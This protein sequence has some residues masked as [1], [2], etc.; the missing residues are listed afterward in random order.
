MGI[1]GKFVLLGGQ[2]V[3]FVHGISFRGSLLR[4]I[5]WPIPLLTGL[6]LRATLV[7]Q[8][9]A[10]SSDF[11]DDETWAIRYMTVE[12]GG[13]L[14]GRPVLISSISILTWIGKR[15]GWTWH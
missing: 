7:N 12:T 15:S 5:G 14:G 11:F 8:P 2:A 1:R 10:A 3:S 13:W 4:A 6:V 9:W